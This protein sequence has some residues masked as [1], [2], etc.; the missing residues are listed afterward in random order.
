MGTDKAL[1]LRRREQ[2]NLELAELSKPDEPVANAPRT[3]RLQAKLR[4]GPGDDRFEREADHI[5][6]EVVRT[7]G[8]RPDADDESISQTAADDRVENSE[9]RVGLH[10]V[11]R[12]QRS[13]TVGLA[14]GD[15]DAD[16]ERA[17]TSQRGGGKP[18]PGPAR[19]SMESAFGADFSGIRVHEGSTSTDLNDRIQAKAF[20]VG[21]D[22]FFRDGMPDVESSQG[23]HL[24]AHELAHTVQQ[25]AARRSIQR[26]TI[27][28]TIQRRLS[29]RAPFPINVYSL[30]G[31]KV[32]TTTPTTQLDPSEVITVDDKALKQAAS[33]AADVAPGWAKIVAAVTDAGTSVADG[34][35][36]LSLIDA[37]DTFGSVAEVAEENLEFVGFMGDIGDDLGSD[38]D[39]LLTGSH[40]ANL[41]YAAGAGDIAGMFLG[42]ATAIKAFKAADDNWDRTEAVLDGISAAGSGAGGIAS[43]AKTATSGAGKTAEAAGGLAMF[44]DIF[45]GIKATFT[46][47]RK[48]VEMAKEADTKSKGEK[49]HDSME[50]VSS[51]LSMAASGVSAAKNFLDTF[52]TGASAALGNAVPGFGIALGA[53]DLLV[54][55]VDLVTGLVHK[56]RMRTDK[57]ASKQGLHVPAFGSVV[58]AEDGTKGKKL[59]AASTYKTLCKKRDN[60]KVAAGSDE[61]RFLTWADN[62]EQFQQYLFSKGLQYINQKRANRALLKISVAMGKIAGDVATLGGASA[63]VGLGLKGG[64]LALDIGASLFRKWKQ[65]F[66]NKRAKKEK[67]GLPISKALMLYN[68]EKSSS[69]KLKTYHGMVT[70]IFK[71]VLAASA[72]PAPPPPQKDMRFA[73][74]TTYL[75]AIGI[76]LAKV[77]SLQ[78]DPNELR[79]EMITYLKKRE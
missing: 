66:R 14:G 38:G 20:T 65:H 77:K 47:V 35:V 67:E 63:P 50:I 68:S 43:I 28:P 24:L 15:V 70:R 59:K 79:K 44:G 16:T 60:G 31:D 30:A 76:S 54:R 64:A 36:K 52:S 58:A 57:Q 18:L 56:G 26:S 25:G 78:N 19:H 71:M 33:D 75:D 41:G 53:A 12:V 1:P 46:M 21:G 37:N 45:E 62:N 48:A 6:D 23:Q 27:T 10:T 40:E 55:S 2:T 3:M 74:V 51:I 9:H 39:G 49:F 42:L 72:L 61:E 32:D 11:S 7:I 4:V 17:I 73:R 29:G 5:A 13:A 69:A 22:V 34:W 8:A